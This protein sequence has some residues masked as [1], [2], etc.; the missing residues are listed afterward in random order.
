MMLRWTES[1][2]GETI[3]DVVL[4]LHEQTLRLHDDRAVLAN[5]SH[6]KATLGSFDAIGRALDEIDAGLRE[7]AGHPGHY[8]R[9]MAKAFRCQARRLQGDPIPY[10]G[11]LADIQELPADLIPAERLERQREKAE[12]GLRRLGYRGAFKAMAQA[13]LG[14]TL[15][16]PDQVTQVAAG[17]VA[18]AKRATLERVIGLP[19]ADGIDDIKSIREVFWSGYSKYLG[20]YRGELTFNIDRP[21]SEPTFAQVLTHEAYPGHQAF[22]SRWDHL[23]QQ[24]RFP[25]EAAYYMIN[26]PTNALF[27]GGPEMA[28]HFLG[29]DEEDGSSP[30]L[31]PEA[32]TRYAVA[33][34]FL[35]FQR[36]A[37]TN[38]C[39]MTNVH[40]VPEAEVLHY[41]TDTGGMN[42]VEA[43]NSYRFFTHPLQKTYYPSYYYGRWL[44]GM[45]YGLVDPADRPAFF[46]LLYDTPQTNSTWIEAVKAL[47]GKDFNPFEALGKP[48]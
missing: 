24:E 16:Q 45:A 21:W 7:L 14:A 33:R 22:Y 8:L 3:V 12:R 42:D 19:E 29:W 27:E 4:S 34:D 1:P 10:A 30:E 5:Y 25:L 2:L 18:L 47:T 37:Q 15:I 31:P 43:R 40:G 38:A 9:A 44:V 17:L 48:A 20:D 6:A 23:F 11:L 26:T 35:D 46:K 28:L 36:M 41:M 32:K 13:W 39:L